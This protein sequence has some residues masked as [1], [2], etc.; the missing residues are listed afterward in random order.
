MQNLFV[1][2]NLVAPVFLIVILGYI[3]KKYKFINDDFVKIS[4]RI[5]FSVSLPAFIFL[6]I[7][8]MHISEILNAELILFV[9]IGTFVTFMLSWLAAKPLKGNGKIKSVFIQGSFRGNFAIVGLALILS[10]FGTEMLPKASLVLAFIIPL[11][12]LL[13]VIALVI[14]M[15]KTNNKNISSA[16]FEIIK[17]PL[18]IAVLLAIPFSI[19]RIPVHHLVVSTGSYLAAMTLP[20][21]LIG[22][23]GFMN[24]SDVKK[25]F[26]ITV[27]SS[28]LKLIVF[29]LIA[30]AAALLLGFNGDDVG[31]IFILFG[32]PT[33]IASFIMAESMGADSKLA[34]NILLA[35]TL[36]SIVTIT[37]GLFILKETGII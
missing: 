14:P 8:R 32:C 26:G 17:N 33:A 20:L 10:V 9:Y 19:L 31:I 1:T 18:I 22:I 5:V 21:A 35:T 34:A 2:L 36:G 25:G 28:I 3:L 13:S 16:F 4:A 29:P 30:V 11:Y 27:Y 7:S 12:N 23:G 37:I 15:R 6:E 24:F